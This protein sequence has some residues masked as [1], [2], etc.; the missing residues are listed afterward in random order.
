MRALRCI[1][2]SVLSV[3]GIGLAH[4]GDL[5]AL[6]RSMTYREVRTWHEEFLR[7]EPTPAERLEAM[8]SVVR[9]SRFG[10]RGLSRVYRNFEGRRSIDPRIPGVEQSLLLQRSESA[11]Q[12]KGY[13]RELLYAIGIHNDPRFSL[14]EMN[15]ALR[16]QWGNT[17]ADIVFRHRPTGLYGRIEI[18]EV[19][20]DSQAANLNALKQQMDK[21]SLE[22][23]RTGQL[24][25]WISRKPVLPELHDYAAKRGVRVL[26]NVNTGNSA[27][28]HVVPLEQAMGAVENDMVRAS[29]RKAIAA[30]TGVAFGVWMLTDS[31]PAFWNASLDVWDP[32]TRTAAAW[33]QLGEASSHALSG[34]GMTVSGGALVAGR[35]GSER[36]GVRTHLLSRTWGI[37]SFAALGI[38]EGFLISRYVYGDIPSR[39]FWIAQSAMGGTAAGSVAG[40]LGGFVLG[41][42]WNPL[43]GHAGAFAGSALGQWTGNRIG[44]ALADHYYDLKFAEL[45]EAYGRAVYGRFGVK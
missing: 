15:R 4:A 23:R 3:A 7:K 27:V 45:D 37:A 10:E 36:L 6:N 30:S 44:T 13:R 2:G 20:R 41:A 24:Q 5:S 8:R 35:L 21:M 18:K 38:G 9:T 28:A 11:P 43:L 16:R 42:L 12:V 31:A 22:A 19:S 29:K 17:D 14:E 26:D 33:R 40:G 34:A 39:E 32:E 1:V 25:F